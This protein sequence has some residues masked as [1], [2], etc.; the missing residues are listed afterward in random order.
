MSFGGK[1]LCYYFALGDYDGL[2]IV[3][4]SDTV[5]ACSMKAASTGAFAP[6]PLPPQ[7]L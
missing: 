3:E 6:R 7:V 1:L 4:F 5:A 2:G